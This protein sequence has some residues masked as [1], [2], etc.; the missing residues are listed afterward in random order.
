MIPV[1]FEHERFFSL[2]QSIYTLSGLTHHQSADA[3][4][5]FMKLGFSSELPELEADFKGV[6]IFGLMGLYNLATTRSEDFSAVSAGKTLRCLTD[7][8]IRADGSR[9]SKST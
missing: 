5:T 1:R 7:N 6:G 8:G 2:L 4:Y 3:H 9:S